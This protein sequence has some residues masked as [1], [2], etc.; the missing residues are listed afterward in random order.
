M[1][2]KIHARH[3]A[4]VGLSVLATAGVAI[5]SAPVSLAGITRIASAS[6]KFNAPKKGAPPATAG[7]ATRGFC[8]AESD[9][10]PVSLV[11]VKQNLGVTL[12]AHPSFFFYVPES[13][14]KTAHFLLLTDEGQTIVFEEKIA[15]PQKSGIV[16]YDLPEAAPALEVGKSYHWYITLT[17][18]DTGPSGNPSIEGWVER[19]EDVA[20]T[21]RL[22]K[23]AQ[24]VRPEIYAQSG[25]W[26]ES[27]KSLAELQRQSPENTK[28]RADWRNLL[29]SVGLDAIANEPL[30]N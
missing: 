17:C 1:T 21:K 22:E 9:R 23:T 16:Q 12:A 10:I 15:L 25:I 5:S 4:L 6:I 7:G 13:R 14:A 28:V 2:R 11:P 19:V 20:L 8:L 27:L 24:S 29:Q 26:H 18:D 30:A 3:F